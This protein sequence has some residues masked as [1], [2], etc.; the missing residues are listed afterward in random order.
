MELRVD[1]NRLEDYN[2]LKTNIPIRAL[3]PDGKWGTCDII[4][5][6]KESL[7]TW[8]RSRGGKNEYAE[9][10]VGLLLGY[11]NLTE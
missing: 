10:L 4:Y 7:L 6:E 2:L 11:G 3:F 1:D 5:L 8:L 9:N